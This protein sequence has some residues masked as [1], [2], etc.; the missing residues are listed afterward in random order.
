MP[1]LTYKRVFMSLFQL[2]LEVFQKYV[3]RN[4]P[5]LI[6]LTE[7]IYPIFKK[8]TQEF[9][10]V[11]IVVFLCISIRVRLTLPKVLIHIFDADR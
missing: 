8:C 7:D 4:V 3:Q 2:S 5:A 10:T 6:F 1:L 11:L 9:Q